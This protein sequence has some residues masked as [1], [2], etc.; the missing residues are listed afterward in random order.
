[1]TSP[2]SITAPAGLQLAPNSEGAFQ[3]TNSGTAPIKITVQLGRTNLPALHYPASSGATLTQLGTPWVSVT[4]AA[5]TLAPHASEQVHISNHVPAG[6]QGDH[7]LQ[8]IWSAQPVHAVSGPLHL[9]GAVASTVMLHEPGVA[10]PVTSHPVP[11]ALPAPHHGGLPVADIG[12]AA[13]GAVVLAA[14]V[15]TIVRRKRNRRNRQA[16]S[17]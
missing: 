7:F 13:V 1:V 8:V 5:F 11:H 3:V 14:A 12:G 2:F 4:P 10:V 15:A 6:T 9:A 16:V 17:A